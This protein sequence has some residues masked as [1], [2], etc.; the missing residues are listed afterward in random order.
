VCACEGGTTPSTLS[1]HSNRRDAGKTK[2]N[3]VDPTYHSDNKKQRPR[4]GGGQLK[5]VG[6]DRPQGLGTVKL[7]NEGIRQ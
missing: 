3:Q 7:R 6:G 1:Q 4:T 5:A 2:H